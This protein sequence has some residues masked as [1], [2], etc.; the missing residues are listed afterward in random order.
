MLCFLAGGKL[1]LTYMQESPAD[2]VA[3]E[4]VLKALGINGGVGDKDAGGEKKVVCDE[5]ACTLQK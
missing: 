1:L 3:P 5:D 2:H 4:D